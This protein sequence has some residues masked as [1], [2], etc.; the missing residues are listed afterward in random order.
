M[1]RFLIL[2]LLCCYL[3][4]VMGVAMNFHFC[5]DKVSSVTFLS[6]ESSK[7]ACEKN[8]GSKKCCHDEFHFLKVKTDQHAA[9]NNGKCLPQEFQLTG[10]N[11]PSGFQKSD[12]Q[13]TKVNVHPDDPP[14]HSSR[15]SIQAMNCVF[16]V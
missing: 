6:F 13:L 14:S 12:L 4:P 1:K 8:A 11:I 7:C 3:I 9:R 2:L 16:R 10:I 15:S 5:K